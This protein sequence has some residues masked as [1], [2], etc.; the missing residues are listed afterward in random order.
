MIRMLLADSAGMTLTEHDIERRKALVALEVPD[1]ERIR[2]VQD[3][4][5][6]DVEGLRRGVLPRRS[7]PLESGVLRILRLSI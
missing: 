7:L 6:R 4:V 2:S 5:E 1:I 3:L